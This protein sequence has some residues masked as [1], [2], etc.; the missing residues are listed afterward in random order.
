MDAFLSAAIAYPTVVF[1]VL[2]GFFLLYAVATVLGAADIEWLDGA[3]GVDDVND[4]VL[5]GALSMLGVSSIPITIVA[6]VATIFAWLSSFFADRF[7]PDSLLLDTGIFVG[8]GA[9]GLL[10]SSIVV[11]P[12]KGLFQVVDGPHRAQIVG[13]IAEVRSLRVDGHSGTADIGGYIAEVRCFRENMLTIGS[14]AIVYDYD[15]KEGLYHVGPID[16]SIAEVDAVLAP[17]PQ[18][19]L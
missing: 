14:K 15:P 4:S 17:R 11:R 8:A 9:I 6:G 5:E 2:L 19:E 12:L 18:A 13:K 3:L 1:T 7:L 10:A 16:A